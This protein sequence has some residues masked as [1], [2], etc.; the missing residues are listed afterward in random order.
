MGDESRLSEPWFGESPLSWIET[1]DCSET[2]RPACGVPRSQPG[3]RPQRLAPD[4]TVP[5]LS[6]FP[7]LIAAAF[8]SSSRPICRA[9]RDALPDYA[10]QL[11]DGAPLGG[12]Q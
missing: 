10:R 6:P 11:R 9:G 7:C 2:E 1:P 3:P 12:G 4:A 5:I 8:P